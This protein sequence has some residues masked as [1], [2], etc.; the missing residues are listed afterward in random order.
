MTTRCA[1]I[2]L[3][4]V[5]FWIVSFAKLSSVSAEDPTII[6]LQSS[7]E[8]FWVAAQGK[9]FDEQLNQWDKYIESEHSEFYSQVVH[10][11][12]ES[13][14]WKLRKEKSAKK[15]FQSLPEIHTELQKR[16]FYFNSVI[17]NQLKNFKKHFPDSNFNEVKIFGAPVLLRF[18]GQGTQINS[19][20][21]LAFGLDMIAYLQTFPESFKGMYYVHSDDVFYLHELFHIYHNEKQ[22]ANGLNFIEKATL[23][24]AAWNEGLATYISFVLNPTSSLDEAFMD[25]ILAEEC[26]PNLD[27]LMTEFAKDVNTKVSDNGSQEKYARWFLI[28]SNNPLIPK[29]AGYCLGYYIVKKLNQ[30]YSLNEMANWNYEFAQD[31]VTE[32][33]KNWT[34]LF[35]LYNRANLLIP[36][37][38]E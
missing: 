15:L 19:K 35:D 28:S 11:K 17:S 8:Q 21:I 27:F 18:N 10:N 29:R 25:R 16:F 36:G 9:D 33:V 20:P 13:H 31:I 30:V 6:N 4:F 22:G 14:D 1:K 26:P 3:L 2:F 12:F 34:P 5:L 38:P 23:A 37:E 7:Y 24:N 32:Q